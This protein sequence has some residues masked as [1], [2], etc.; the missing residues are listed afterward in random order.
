MEIKVLFI[1][2]KSIISDESFPDHDDAQPT[3]KVF[4]FDLPF[5]FYFLF[6]FPFALCRMKNERSVVI[7]NY[8][9]NNILLEITKTNKE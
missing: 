7:N 5:L 3:E 9:L 6:I 8:K 2:A 1:E 4:Q